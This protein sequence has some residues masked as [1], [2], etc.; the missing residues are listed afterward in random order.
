MIPAAKPNG[1]K[2]TVVLNI[3]M[4]VA[5]SARPFQKIIV[6]HCDPK[7]T[8]EYDNVEGELR[9]DTPSPENFLPTRRPCVFWKI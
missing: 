9:D 8:K 3:I 5:W 6:V 2:T 1:G 7:Q 4:R